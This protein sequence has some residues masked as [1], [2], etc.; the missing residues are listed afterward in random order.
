[1]P[2]RRNEPSLPYMT[3]PVE[4]RQMKEKRT[5]MKGPENEVE[6]EGDQS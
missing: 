1:M 5:K 3:N 2:Q 4:V 6:E